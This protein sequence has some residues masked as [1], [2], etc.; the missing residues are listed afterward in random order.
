MHR[1]A[2]TGADDA[3]FADPHVY[4]A[5]RFPDGSWLAGFFPSDNSM[6]SPIQPMDADGRPGPTADRFA[7]SIARLADPERGGS[8]AALADGTV[9]FVTQDFAANRATATKVK[10]DGTVVRQSTFAWPRE[11]VLG[12]AIALRSARSRTPP[13]ARWSRGTAAA[14]RCSTPTSRGSA[15]SW[16]SGG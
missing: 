9:L 11:N 16:S 10:R 7:G 6:S 14:S 1:L 15:G 13:P 8:Y 2:P 3:S 4:L 12:T 5:G